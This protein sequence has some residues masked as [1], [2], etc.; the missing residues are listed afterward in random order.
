MLLKLEA[1]ASRS[2][3]WQGMIWYVKVRYVTY[4]DILFASTATVKNADSKEYTDA[5]KQDLIFPMNSSDALTTAKL[6][7]LQRSAP[8]DDKHSHKILATEWLVV[9]RAGSIPTGM[10]IAFSRVCLS[11]C[12]FVRALKGKR[13]ELSTP[14]FVHVYAIAVAR[15]AL[16]QRSK[17]K[18]QG[19]TFMKTVTVARLLMMHAATAV[20]CCC[21]RGSACWYDCRCFLV[22]YFG[23]CCICEWHQI[24]W[25]QSVGTVESNSAAI[26]RANP[27]TDLISVSRIFPATAA[28][29]LKGRQLCVG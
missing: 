5:H 23:L 16:T 1:L 3:D 8:K 15:H 11:V 14:I 26:S 25:D 4:Y 6:P 29:G 12:L 13:L 10:G 9:T 19:H 21:R 20:C 28:A 18:G 22:S 24:H 7:V 2:Q 17:V 27:W